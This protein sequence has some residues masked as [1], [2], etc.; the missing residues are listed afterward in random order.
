MSLIIRP[1]TR[2]LWPALE[3]LFGSGS[4]CSRCWCMYWRIGPAYRR[5]PAEANKT[6][7]RTVV[8]A[9][10]PPGLLA[11]Q[12]DL[13]IGWCQVTPRDG[14]PWLDRAEASSASTTSR[15][16]RSRASTSGYLTDGTGR[17]P[18]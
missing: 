6:A 14:V 13:A 11:F 12:G 1:L 9:G 15:C 18:R 8:E 2:D 4:P 7:F 16:G 3:D 5:R 17:R 10:P